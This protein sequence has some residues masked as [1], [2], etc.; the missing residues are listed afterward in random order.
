MSHCGESGYSARR[1]GGVRLRRS[2]LQAAGKH[3]DALD[4]GRE[5]SDVIDALDVNEFADL[6]EP[7]FGVAAGHDRAA[8]P[9]GGPGSFVGFPLGGDAK[10]PSQARH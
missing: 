3:G 7:N 5:R 9:A 10:P 4:I 2:G 6:L 8:G 1:L